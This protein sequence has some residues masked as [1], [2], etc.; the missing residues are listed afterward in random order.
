VH[1]VFE[2]LGIPDNAR[3][4]DVRRACAR[5]VRRCHPDFRI[6]GIST[7]L[8][9]LSA[10]VA[11]SAASVREIAVDFVDASVFVERMQAAF[12]SGVN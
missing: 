3:A 9:G 1:D 7:D 10:P 11:F 2:V 8:E 5:R 6:P 12:F 4:S